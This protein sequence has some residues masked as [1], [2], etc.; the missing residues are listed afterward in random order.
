MK[1]AFLTLAFL[2][3]SALSAQT[4][5]SGTITHGGLTREYR[6]YV[7]A[8]YSAATPAPLVFNLHGYTSDM[9]QQEFYG[10][11]RPIA[12]TAG[13]LL[14]H[15]NGTLDGGGNRFWNVGFFPSAVDDVG[16]LEAL[17]DSLSADYSI[18]P[19]RVYSAGMSNGGFMGYH[20]ACNSDR[21]AAIASV[22][23]SM[24]TA[25][26]ASCSPT[27]PIP[28]IEIHGT[29]DGTVPYGGTTGMKPIAD[30]LDYWATFNSCPTPPTVATVPNTAVFD[31]ATAEHH[32]YAPGDDGVTIEHFK[33]ISGA[34][35]WPG[36]P[37]VIGVT[38][39]DFD[40]SEEIW[41][42]FSQHTLV[43][44]RGET[45]TE[46][47]LQ[48]S[49][50]PV[51]DE[52]HVTLDVSGPLSFAVLDG[53]GREVMAGIAQGGTFTLAAGGLAPGFYLL[54][55]SDGKTEAVKRFVRM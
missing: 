18:D 5:I 14:V 4:T 21:F 39:M 16:F 33:V 12:D 8:S 38:C 51:A 36:A 25:T 34:H 48:I 29:A 19:S 15:P 32:V 43:T 52:L 54:R 37:I 28:V 11:F 50:V 53:T 47:A 1:S 49:P 41:R 13:F 6:L 35:T 45:L 10:D 2:A 24:S 55:L 3:A 27:R 44:H 42:F 17:M 31:G 30:V 26:Y 9:L 20:L 23:G 46:Q 22:T 7:P 40:A